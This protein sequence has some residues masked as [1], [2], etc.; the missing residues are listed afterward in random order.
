M[1]KKFPAGALP[2]SGVLVL[3][4]FLA[5]ACSRT[6]PT[7]KQSDSFTILHLSDT[8]VC[9]LEGA[10][11]R[12]VEKRQQY[13][14]GFNALRRV[15]AVLPERVDAEAAAITGDMLD[16]WEIESPE[17]KLL[18][19]QVERF[20][21]AASSSPVP[22]WLTLGNH[23]IRTHAVSQR[24]VA[25][26]G[27]PSTLQPHAE[28]ARS[29]WVR[30]MECFR[31]GTYYYKDITVGSSA[32]RLYFLDDGYYLEDDPYGNLWD[33]AQLYWLENELDKTPERKAILFF[34]IPLPV[35]DINGD[36]IHFKK[37]PEGWPFPDTYQEGIF[38]ILNDHP[39][40]VAAFVGHNHD[41]IIEDIPFPAGH[42]VTQVETGAFAVNNDNWRVIEI[43]EREISI[44]KPGRTD[45]EKV[46]QLSNQG[47]AP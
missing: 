22:L 11:P 25:R 23:D 12:L 18:T 7:A 30:R 17:G 29:A 2:V 15:L 6:A 46:V 16:S 32:W 24:V 28:A 31:D 10:H 41:N 42:R 44:S 21:A 14:Q 38:K 3:C 36:G 1:R 19:N 43:Q 26:K 45:V 4:L 47:V 8:H 40:V 33:V 27:N 20:A 9:Q 35:A 5:P 37:P 34:H 39:A 13:N